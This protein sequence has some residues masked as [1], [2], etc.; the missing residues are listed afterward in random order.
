MTDT[1]VLVGDSITETGR[2]DHP[3][4]GTGY[5]NLIAD[6]LAPAR[7][8]NSGIGGDRISD[9]QARWHEDVLA[10]APTLLSVS[11]EYGLM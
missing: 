9:L 2:F 5:V 8:I 11:T 3:P 7:I 6:R 10:H 1:V 4:L